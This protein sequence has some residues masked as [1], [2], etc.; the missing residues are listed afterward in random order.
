MEQATNQIQELTLDECDAV[1][2]GVKMKMSKA[3]RW[4]LG[5]AF[6]YL[7]SLDWASG[8]EGSDQYDAA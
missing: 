8:F 5:L 6:D 1:S 4:G 3:I 7:T 2:G